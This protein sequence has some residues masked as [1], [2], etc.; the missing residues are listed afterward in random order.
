MGRPRGARG[1][2]PLKITSKNKNSSHQPQRSTLSQH[3]QY[4]DLDPEVDLSSDEVEETPKQKAPQKPPPITVVGQDFQKLKFLLFN[5]N[6]DLYT[7]KISKFGIQI[8]PI[9]SDAFSTIRRLLIKKE[10]QHFTH[11]LKEEQLSKFV[12]HGF[13]DGTNSELKLGGFLRE[14]QLGPVKIKKLKIK[15]KRNS[16][17]AVYLVYFQNSD[18]MKLSKLREIKAIDHVIVRWEYYSNRRTGPTQCSNCLLFG[19]GG[20]NCHLRPRCI[21]CGESHKSIDC[22]K[23]Y[24]EKNQ[25]TRTRIADA[26]LKCANCSK[27]HAA[28]YSGCEKRLEVI[29]RQKRFKLQNQKHPS[30][31]V[32]QFK[33]APQLNDF[34]YPRLNPSQRIQNYSIQSNVSQG[35]NQNEELFSPGELME[36]FKEMVSRMQGATSKLEQLTIISDM[37]VKYVT[38]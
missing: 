10:I 33:P 2:I 34:N 17:H 26:E 7:L 1:K 8:F 30:K 18:N 28:N 35:L 21:R 12:L 5:V 15:H 4:M 38:R 36:I 22:P 27:N 16:D 25:Q 29:E 13:Y 3:N 19:H 23:L 24:D 32:T 9:H 20:F 37:I 11:T 14:L 6:I 31:L